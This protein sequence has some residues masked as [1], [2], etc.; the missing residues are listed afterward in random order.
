MEAE[1]PAAKQTYRAISDALGQVVHLN[2][3]LIEST[4]SALKT[5]L[6]TFNRKYGAQFEQTRAHL[7]LLF[8]A[9]YQSFA[10][11]GNNLTI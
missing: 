4:Y 9:N 7:S 11:R 1:E 2:K 5:D 8:A 10:R 6:Q 3:G